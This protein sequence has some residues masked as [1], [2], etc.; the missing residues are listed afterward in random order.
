MVS[1][2]LPV[3][4]GVWT[5]LTSFWKLTKPNVLFLIVF[6][7]AIGMFLSI[8]AGSSVHW[9]KVV[10][11]VLGIWLV[12]AAAAVINCLVEYKIDALMKRT[13]NRPLPKS[14][15]NPI[16]AMV[17]SIIVGLLGA[18]V[19][20]F[21]VNDLTLILTL[22]TF[23]GYAFLYTIILKPITPQNIVI[24][25]ASGSMPPVL[26]WAAMSGSLTVHPWILFLIIFLWTPPH[27]W[28]LSLYRR[29]EYA[30]VGFPMLPVT[31]GVEGTLRS[32][33]LYVVLLTAASFLPC[34][35]ALSGEFYFFGAVIL[36]SYF[37]KITLSLWKDYSDHKARSVFFYSIL[38]LFLLFLFMLLD[39]YWLFY[40]TRM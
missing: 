33:V 1:T 28:S 18:A 37:I 22:L 6:C 10:E 17:F 27:F 8:P 13:R 24:G 31:H 19:L 2:E 34:L 40:W 36:G 32:I 38:Y 26:G 35:V 7:A 30:T 3:G 23:I 12:A 4:A 25:G 9:L 5:R 14:L 11:A 29:E 21:F 39:H 16:E 15:L 20:H